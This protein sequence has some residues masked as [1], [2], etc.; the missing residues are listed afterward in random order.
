MD[1]RSLGARGL[2]NLAYAYL[3][4]NY[5]EH[6]TGAAEQAAVERKKALD[7]GE[8][9]KVIEAAVREFD[10]D[11]ESEIILAPGV[12]P[13]RISHARRNAAALAG[14]MADIERANE[15]PAD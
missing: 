14:L 4:T 3:L 15:S 7:P 11:I 12:D 1:I 9:R 13:V 10:K 2:A 6:Q 8:R 5:V